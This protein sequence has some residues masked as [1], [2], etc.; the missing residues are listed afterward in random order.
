MRNFPPLGGEL[1]SCNGKACS[2]VLRRLR[3]SPYNC[4]SRLYMHSLG[5]ERFGRVED[6]ACVQT[7]IVSAFPNVNEILGLIG[8]CQ[9]PR[10]D[11]TPAPLYHV[12]Q[13]CTLITTVQKKLLKHG[14]VAAVAILTTLVECMD[15]MN[16][17]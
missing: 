8:G 10:F 4:D 13:A 6:I 2:S 15:S 17:R 16:R 12:R 14:A 3:R 1:A 11:R 7:N 5:H 9:P